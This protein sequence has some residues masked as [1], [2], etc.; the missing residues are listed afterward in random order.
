MYKTKPR[1]LS[2]FN[3][4]DFCKC[5]PGLKFYLRFQNKMKK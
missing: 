4:V 3:I 5:D 2:E 1:A